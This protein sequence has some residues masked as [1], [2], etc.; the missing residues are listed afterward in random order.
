[1]HGVKSRGDAD[2]HSLLRNCI[3]QPK[4]LRAPLG[5]VGNA[6]SSGNVD[7]QG[8]VNGNFGTVSGIGCQI[9]PPFV[10]QTT[11]LDTAPSSSHFRSRL[12]A[13]GRSMTYSTHP[14][15]FATFYV[16]C[17]G[18][19]WYHVAS[20][21]TERR[22]EKAG[23]PSGWFMVVG[24]ELMCGGLPGIWIPGSLDFVSTTDFHRGLNENTTQLQSR[25]QL[26]SGEWRQI[27]C[28]A[29]VITV[30]PITVRKIPLVR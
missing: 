30:Q 23:L 7:A 24:F 9:D 16:L 26:L 8:D 14:I 2:C 11:A 18:I 22:R 21:A 27:V 20:E 6:R 1:M 12:T 5:T 19:A 13:A 28:L 10:D 15:E 3:V 29:V 17:L 4:W 25:D